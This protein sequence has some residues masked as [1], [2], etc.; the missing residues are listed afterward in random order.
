MPEHESAR[1][2][3]DDVFADMFEEEQDTIHR[4]LE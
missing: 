2:I 3:T 4:G 1:E